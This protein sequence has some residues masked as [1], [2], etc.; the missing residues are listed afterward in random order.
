[1]SNAMFW[2]PSLWEV[3]QDLHG[4]F[5]FDPSLGAAPGADNPT[6]LPFKLRL[7][8]IQQFLDAANPMLHTLLLSGY[9]VPWIEVGFQ[10]M[11]LGDPDRDTATK[12]LRIDLQNRRVEVNNRS[13][14]EGGGLTSN[15]FRMKVLPLRHGSVQYNVIMPSG[16]VNAPDGQLMYA[17]ARCAREFTKPVRDWVGERLKDDSGSNLFA[18]TGSDASSQTLLQYRKAR[19]DDLFD[20]IKE[21][22]TCEFV[23]DFRYTG[24]SYAD[25]LCNSVLRLIEYTLFDTFSWAVGHEL[26]S[27][28]EHLVSN[29]PEGNPIYLPGLMWILEPTVWNTFRSDRP[30]TTSGTHALNRIKKLVEENWFWVE[31]RQMGFFYS[32]Y[33]EAD[34][35]TS[36]PDGT[37]NAPQSTDPVTPIK[38]IGLIDA[39]ACV[40]RDEIDLTEAP[41]LAVAYWHAHPA[42]RFIDLMVGGDHFFSFRQKRSANR[43]SW[44]GKKA[45]NDGLL[46]VNPSPEGHY[47]DL[48]VALDYNG[49]EDEGALNR[50][51]VNAK[52]K[53]LEGDLAQLMTEMLE[54]GIRTNKA[55]SKIAMTRPMSEFIFSL[56]NLGI[57]AI[58]GVIGNPADDL[59]EADAVAIRHEADAPLA[60]RIN[61]SHPHYDLNG[62]DLVAVPDNLGG[63]TLSDCVAWE[64]IK[65]PNYPP[66]LKIEALLGQVPGLSTTPSDKLII[67]AAPGVE[68]QHLSAWPTAI[69]VE[70]F[71]VQSHAQVPDR[72]EKIN[73]Q[74]LETP[75]PLSILDG[76]RRV[77]TPGEILSAEDATARLNLW[78]TDL[79]QLEEAHATNRERLPIITVKPVREEGLSGLRLTTSCKPS[80]YAQH[81]LGTSSIEIMA[82]ATS[83]NDRFAFEIQYDIH[84]L[85]RAISETVVDDP[86]VLAPE[87][88]LSGI[89]HASGPRTV[90]T[91]D[92]VPV[93]QFQIVIHRTANVL[94]RIKDDYLGV[95]PIDGTRAYLEGWGAANIPGFSYMLGETNNVC[96]YDFYTVPFEDIPPLGAVLNRYASDDLPTGW[97]TYTHPIDTQIWD[98]WEEHF[99]FIVDIGVG[100]MPYGIGDAVDVIE[101]G[102]MMTAG[103]DKW[104]RPVSN[105]EIALS[106]GGMCLPFVSNRAMRMIATSEIAEEALEETAELFVKLAQEPG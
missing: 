63:R 17:T 36:N 91:Y 58:D 76:M 75:F 6:V 61:L 66:G 71:R 37:V 84:H 85:Q 97:S 83:G 35:T 38:R 65:A 88:T 2:L 3:D 27:V 98:A 87:N 72:D 7:S 21:E 5:E 9:A 106:F 20:K 42:G 74:A 99:K 34:F 95:G 101:F 59:P 8:E 86:P 11:G 77:E 100:F 4:Q 22:D 94:V 16:R 73:L 15:M 60:E 46:K 23:L 70:I 80:V 41:D 10:T 45:Q 49:A 51:L 44:A 24:M 96:L 26:I 31:H 93:V 50:D 53:N 1:M 43:M 92:T 33:L 32:D 48:F 90:Y 67:V 14:D 82:P 56:F 69:P 89:S 57:F 104:G 29:T 28:T 54:P 18:A 25:R 103:C 12:W 55:R 30:L 105:F 64:Y 81:V 13:P 40:R 79:A 78:S 68:I 39:L 47:S 52:L 102:L 62:I 19:A